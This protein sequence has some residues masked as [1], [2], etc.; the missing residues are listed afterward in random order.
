MFRVAP[1]IVLSFAAQLPA[2]NSRL[3]K[4]DQDRIVCVPVRDKA[5]EPTGGEICRTG[6]QWE[7][8]L[9]K[10][11]ATNS[12]IRSPPPIGAIATPNYYRQNPGLIPRR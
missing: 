9:R 5:G 8:A 7:L 2:Q 10:N 1:I 3:P 12:E 4:L 11:R 6:R